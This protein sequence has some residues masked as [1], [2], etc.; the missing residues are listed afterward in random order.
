MDA[1]FSVAS[2]WTLTMESFLVSFSYTVSASCKLLCSCL[3]VL[4]AGFLVRSIPRP[5]GIP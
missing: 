2:L 3:S 5:S 1:V 4:V